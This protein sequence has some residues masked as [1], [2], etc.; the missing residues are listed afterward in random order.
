V[1]EVLRIKDGKVVDPDKSKSS[2]SAAEQ[3]EKKS[4]K[5][6][7]KEEAAVNIK[8][9]SRPKKGIL[10]KIVNIFTPNQTKK[11]KVKTPPK[12]FKRNNKKKPI[13]KN[14]NRNQNNRNRNFDNK[15][16]KNDSRPKKVAKNETIKPRKL[17]RPKN[18]DNK[19]KESK[20]ESFDKTP[21]KDQNKIDKKAIKE[22]KPKK[23]ESVRTQE[24]VKPRKLS[25]P[26]QE[27]SVPSEQKEVTRI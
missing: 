15:K 19:I 22:D 1:F 25:R 13:P 18:P 9:S 12:N 21:I 2:V 6:F 11:V 3:F 10:S 4:R 26:K 24:V 20:K 8:P 27:S 17:S 23:T 7:K 5:S 14:T 16:T